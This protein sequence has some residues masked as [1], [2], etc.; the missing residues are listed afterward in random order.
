MISN[1]YN[2]DELLSAKFD[3]IE[4]WKDYDIYTEVENVGQKVKSTRWVNT[5]KNGIIKSRLVA[6]GYEDRAE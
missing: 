2:P 1:G 6:Q 3:E 4:K 5:V